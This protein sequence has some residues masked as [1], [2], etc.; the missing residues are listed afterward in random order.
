[1]TESALYIAPGER[2]PRMPEKTSVI[3]APG[4]KTENGDLLVL[5][6]TTSDATGS[7]DI[8][9]RVM[10]ENGEINEF[11]RTMTF[12]GTGTQTEVVA[13]LA[14]GWIVGF[15]VS[16]ASGTLTDG[17]VVASV[18]ICRN[19]GSL[20]QKLMCL[21]SGEVTSIRSLGLG[22]FLIRGPEA[23]ASSLPDIQTDLAAP[24]AGA[25]ITYTVPAGEVWEIQSLSFR[26]VTSAT[27][28]TRI[29][30]VVCTDG[31]DRIGRYEAASSQTAGQTRDYQSSQLGALW[32]PVTGTM[33]VIPMSPV[34]LKE[35]Y[36]IKTDTI[37]IQVGDQY[38]LVALTYRL[39][40]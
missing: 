37:S 38:S 36:I 31:T 21:A 19:A 28:A 13:P 5:S 2:A 1:M 10:T 18:H 8:R 9:G 39:H 25:E 7:V 17:E 22:A 33:F 29:V 24:A 40:T 4:P 14:A 23:T 32:T 16:R 12:S 6:L 11:G 34:F 15:D 3:A 27:A 35:G 26:L 30:A 20:L